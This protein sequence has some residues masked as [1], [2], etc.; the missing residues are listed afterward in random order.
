M[1]HELAICQSGRLPCCG[2]SIYRIELDAESADPCTLAEFLRS[3]SKSHI[4]R[5]RCNAERKVATHRFRLRTHASNRPARSAKTIEARCLFHPSP[6]RRSATPMKW[7][8]SC[9]VLIECSSGDVTCASVGPM[10]GRLPTG[11]SAN[12]ILIVV[13][14]ALSI[15]L[16]RRQSVRLRWP[17]PSA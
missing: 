12:V 9:D 11:A 16:C 6:N 14:H 3:S 7:A 1:Q 8:E 5:P 15:N 13:G 4:R 10:C 17:T 2:D